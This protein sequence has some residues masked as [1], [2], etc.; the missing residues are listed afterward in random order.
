MGEEP[1]GRVAH[2]RDA[3]RVAR[4]VVGE[5]VREV[6]AYV[7][8]PKEIR[9][10]KWKI[11]RVLSDYGRPVCQLLVGK[12]AGNHGLLVFDGAGARAGWDDDRIPSTVQD[13]LKG[14]DVVLDQRQ[15]VLEIPGIDVHLPTACLLSWEEHFV[16]EALEE[17]H[18][19]AGCLRKHR[20]PHTGRENRYSHL[21]S[22]F[23]LH[24]LRCWVHLPSLGL[25]WLTRG[26]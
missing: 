17:R 15:S 25:F 4:R 23:P 26:A 1:F 2:F 3:H 6:C 7:L 10:Q 5:G 21:A 12:F 16:A 9:E 24:P 14:L 19:R 13:R 8:D 20:I 18:R 11:I 22:P